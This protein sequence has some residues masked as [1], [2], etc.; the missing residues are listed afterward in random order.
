MTNQ[1]DQEFVS[2]ALAESAGSL[3]EFLPSLG[4]S[5]AI[6]IGEGVAL[7]MRVCFDQLP[8]AAIP[9]GKGGKFSEAWSKAIDDEGLLQDVVAIWRNEKRAKAS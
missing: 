5:E 1:S 3:F 9:Q 2:A 4:D 7:P 6:A 8:A